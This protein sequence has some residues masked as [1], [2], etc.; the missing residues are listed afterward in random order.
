MY[1]IVGLGNPGD[2]YAH[3]RHNVGFDVLDCL[4]K[5][6]QVTITREKEQALI[7]QCF[8]GGK[9]VILCKPQTFMNLSGEAVSRLCRFFDIEPEHLMVIYDDVDLPQGAIR[10]R[11]SGSA[12]THNGMRNIVQLLGYDNFPRLRVGIGE[13]RDG[14]ELADWVLGHYITPEEK[15]A[16]EQAFETA[17]LAVEEYICDGIDNAMCRYNTKKEKKAKTAEQSQNLQE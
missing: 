5:K 11:K 10:I 6:Q 15:A 2:K 17:A 7:G 14:Y 8:I 12:G 3:T 13:K 4:A 16:A 1:L 9:K